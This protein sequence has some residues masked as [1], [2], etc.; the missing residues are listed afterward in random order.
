MIRTDAVVTGDQLI[1]PNDRG[2]SYI[3]GRVQS[4][5]QSLGW[6]NGLN[7]L[8]TQPTYTTPTPPATPSGGR[9]G[10]AIIISTI[11]D[12]FNRADSTT[13]LGVTS[14]G[15]LTWNALA[16]TWGISSNKG[17]CVTGTE[18]T[19]VVDTSFSDG[20]FEVTVT[21][22]SGELGGGACLAFRFADNGNGWLLYGGSFGS[23][24]AGF[25][26][27]AKKVAG[28]FTFYAPS[29]NVTPVSGD[30]L[31]IDVLGSS[32]TAKVNGSTVATM[33]D[34]AFSTATQHGLRANPT[35]GVNPRFDTFSAVAG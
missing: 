25:W 26:R 24:G 6:S 31:H 22:D 4:A 7:T 21:N 32:I 19:A 35:I 8:G 33:T 17:Y 13:T 34:S 1:H 27:L 14:V 5:L 12:D 3:A 2:A 16:G 11:S 18:A 15:A 9:T 20:A 30:V 23:P 29:V 10:A 28:G